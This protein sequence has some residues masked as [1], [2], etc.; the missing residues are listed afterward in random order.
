MA[1]PLRLEY[2]GA[3]YHV[4]ARGHERSPIY[5]DDED[6]QR[7]L[8]D[9][10]RVVEE[11]RFVV[12]AYCL[13]TNHY[14]MLIETPVAN[15]AAGM[16]RLNARYSQAFNFRHGRTGHLLESRYKAL[17]IEK[18]SY[19]LELS[20]YVVLNP[21]R[22]GLVRS[23]GAWRWSNFRATYGET[24]RPAF[25]E[26]DWTLGCFG[27]KRARAREAYRR[28]VSEGKSAADPID[29]ADGQAFLGSP[30]FLDEMKRRLDEGAALSAEIPRAQR[31][32]VFL[33]LAQI[34]DAVAE[35]YGIPR[36]SLRAAWSRGEHRA[37]VAY[38]ARK[39]TGLPATRIAEF[40][41]VSGGRVSQLVRQVEESDDGGLAGHV[42]RLRRRL[43]Q[44]KG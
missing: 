6:R 44:A 20:R 21:V 29:K 14:H 33:S 11:M 32:A 40:L 35:E 42:D 36:E 31:Q 12:H 41:G 39:L 7:F 9:L 28:F 23:A 17:V 5:R 18:E 30:A 3:V 8:G 27:T 2:P 37:I 4:M 25:L 10:A 16:H 38:L 15:L 43:S 26:I 24:E 22:A 1:R 34:S 13:M 19:L